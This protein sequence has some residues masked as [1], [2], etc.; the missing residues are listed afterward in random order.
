[1]RRL[2]FVVF[3]VFAAASVVSFSSLSASAQSGEQYE[4]SDGAE[5]PASPLE[6]EASVD[7]QP[8]TDFISQG[9]VVT[10]ERSQAAAEAARKDLNE[11]ESLPDYSQVVDNTMKGAFRASG[12]EPQ[13]GAQAHGGGF[14]VA[15]GTKAKAARFE[16]KIPTTSDYAVYAWWSPSSKNSPAA[17]YGIDTASGVKWTEVDQR[18]DGGMW[19]K[20]GTYEMK[21]GERS[22][23]VS[24]RPS[25]GGDVVAP[26]VAVVRGDLTAPP[27]EEAAASPSTSEARAATDSRSR[28]TGRDVVRQARRHL[29]TPYGHSRCR[30][31]VQ[32]DCTCH[33]KLVF[34]KFGYNLS[35]MPGQQ[36]KYGRKIAKSDLRPGDLVFFDDTGDGNMNDAHDGVGIY[37]GRGWYISGNSYFGKVVEKEMKWRKGYEGARRLRLR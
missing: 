22:I 35:D 1:M 21:K 25:T 7:D 23:Q 28:S 12:W 37:S 26:A 20:L 16:V 32:E 31:D 17:R 5:V 4:P 34:K 3:A 15:E 24:G 13:R 30:I 14:V 27:E 29:G 11:E 8:G 9:N 18:T 19:M 2:L 10:G 36:Y 33:T 6:S